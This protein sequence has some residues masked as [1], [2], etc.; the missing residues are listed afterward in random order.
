MTQVSGSQIQ[1]LMTFFSAH[2]TGID[3]DGRDPQLAAHLRTLGPVRPNPTYSLSSTS[4]PSS[5][6]T[7]PSASSTHDYPS[8]AP[9]TIPSPRNNPALAILA[10]RQRVQDEHERDKVESGKKGWKGRRYVDVGTLRKALV[11]RDEKGMKA[12]EI[13]RA[14]DLREG[15]VAGLGRQ[16]VVE[17]T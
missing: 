17:A 1:R 7:E 3:L 14:L 16:G 6:V 13:E 2:H 9:S 8:D 12:A 4:S 11:L 10:A 5:A 15:F